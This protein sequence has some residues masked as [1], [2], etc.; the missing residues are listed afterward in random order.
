MCGILV[1]SLVAL[2]SNVLVDKPDENERL[3]YTEKEQAE[4]TVNQTYFTLGS[5]KDEVIAVQGK[6]SNIV[7]SSWYY[8][9]SRVDFE[10]D[11]VIAYSDRKEILKIELKPKLPSDKKYFVLGLTMDE[12]LSIQGR[13][14]N[15]IGT[16]LTKNFYN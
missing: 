2:F 8:G 3:F 5:T 15:I 16:T 4:N 10:N 14:S 9:A 11:K 13:P 1:I 12:V 7:E 6:L